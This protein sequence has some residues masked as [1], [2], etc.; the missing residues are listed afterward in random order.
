MIFLDTHVVVWLYAGELERLNAHVRRSI[1][2]QD[3][4]I[5]PMVVLELQY[6][7]ETGRLTVEAP[8]IVSALAKTLG[9]QVCDLE[10]GHVILEALAQVWTRDPFDRLIVAQ[11][12]ARDLPLLTKDD[13][14]LAHYRKAFWD[15]PVSVRRAKQLAYKEQLNQSSFGQHVA[16]K[17]LNRRKA[18][19]GMRGNDAAHGE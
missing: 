8:V 3:L 17:E 11:A 15:S 16:K 6:L 13:T 7:K 14:I 10:F 1:E 2:E 19:K 12:A 5:S 9:L 18:R 4:L